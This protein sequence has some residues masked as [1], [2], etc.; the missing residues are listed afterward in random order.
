MIVVVVVFTACNIRFGWHVANKTGVE[1]L[2]KQEDRM[3][4]DADIII[5]GMH[6]GPRPTAMRS[7]NE[8]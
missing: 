6:L 8:A 5:R 2:G 7:A 1:V 4:S 3:E